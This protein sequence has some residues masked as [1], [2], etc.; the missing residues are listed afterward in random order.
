MNVKFEA[1]CPRKGNLYESFNF[2]SQ[3]EKYQHFFLLLNSLLNYLFHKTQMMIYILHGHIKSVG[4][5][6]VNL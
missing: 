1:E 6:Q 3:R 2:Y 4:K 5:K